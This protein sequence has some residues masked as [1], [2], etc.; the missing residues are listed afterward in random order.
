MATFDR[1][2][3][4]KRV[5]DYIVPWDTLCNRTSGPDHC[6]RPGLAS[7][8]GTLS[9]SMFLENRPIL[10]CRTSNKSVART[11]GCIPIL[12]LTMDSLS[13]TICACITTRKPQ[14]SGFSPLGCSPHAVVENTAISPDFKGGSRS[15]LN[16]LVNQGVL[17]K[18]KI[19]GHIR[20]LL[21][22]QSAHRKY[23][24]EMNAEIYAIAPDVPHIKKKMGAIIAAFD[25]NMIDLE[26]LV[27]NE[28]ASQL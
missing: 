10:C 14:N 9:C 3:G 6:R 1:T 22:E 2:V 12:V 24:L 15:D 11:K 8:V 23:L 28:E 21:E 19:I 13:A 18:E 20:G 16:R 17:S 5:F 27:A 7:I 25:Q 26:S 4:S